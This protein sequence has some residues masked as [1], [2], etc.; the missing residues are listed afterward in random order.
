[1]P[2]APVEGARDLRADPAR[3]A[4]DDGHSRYRQILTLWVASS[5]RPAASVARAVS[6]CLPAAAP[7]VRHEPSKTPDTPRRS[8]A[9]RRPSA[10]KWTERTGDVELATTI[11]GTVPL[12]HSFGDGVAHVSVSPGTAVIDMLRKVVFGITSSLTEETFFASW[13]SEPDRTARVLPFGIRRAVAAAGRARP[14]R[15]GRRTRRRRGRRGRR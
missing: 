6:T 11:S 10:R 3:R 13:K 1:M 15:P 8:T 4:G 2:A 12:T 5:V 9:T 7:R 14:R